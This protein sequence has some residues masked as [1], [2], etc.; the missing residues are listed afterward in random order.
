MNTDDDL[1]AVLPINEDSVDEGVEEKEMN[2]L[3]GEG[4]RFAAGLYEDNENKDYLVGTNDLNNVDASAD[5]GLGD[6]AAMSYDEDDNT[7]PA[8]NDSDVTATGMDESDADNMQGK[9]NLGDV[10]L[11]D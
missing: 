6:D 5:E 10:V 8:E 11:S 7:L 2:S 4:T 9:E 3:D 1:N